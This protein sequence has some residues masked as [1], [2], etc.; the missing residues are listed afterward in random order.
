VKAGLRWN[1]VRGPERI[2]ISLSG[3]VDEFAS[4]DILLEELPHNVPVRIDLTHVDRINSV[5]VRNWIVFVDK[6]RL[7]HI[8]VELDGCSVVIVRQMNMILQF[9]GHGVVRSAYA[10]YYCSRCKKEQ[11][12]LIDLTVD[13]ATQLHAPLPCPTCGTVLDL[14]EEEQL[15]TELQA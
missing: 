1:V 6:L 3:A 4:L 7:H 5:G 13:V 10:P 15:Y 9:R 14:D 2:D 12:R 8:E 11:L